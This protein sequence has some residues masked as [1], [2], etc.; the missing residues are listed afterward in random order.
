MT[1]QSVD[2]ANGA[3]VFEA[4]TFAD[5]AHYGQYR[6]GTELPYMQHLMGALTIAVHY[7][8][9]EEIR[10]AV[11]LH[12]TVEDTKTTLAKI[13]KVFGPRVAHLVDAATDDKSMD[14]FERK[15]KKID[16]IRKPH[17]KGGA[18]IDERIV[19]CCDK[20]HNITSIRDNWKRAKE[21][22]IDFW[23]AFSHDEKEYKWYY[24]ELAKAFLANR[25]GIVTSRMF[26]EFADVVQDVFG[27]LDGINTCSAA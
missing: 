27:P 7:D 21:A 5:T 14:W 2:H 4:I 9:S 6:P 23:D 25:Q 26:T 19:I 1:K 16:Y 17:N 3:R 11:V 13:E 24:H 22:G 20:L 18:T 12:D 15:T 8:C 10:M